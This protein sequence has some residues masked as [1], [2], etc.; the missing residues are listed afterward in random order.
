MLLTKEVGE[1]AIGEGAIGEG[2]VG[3]GAIGGSRRRSIGRKVAGE[4]GRW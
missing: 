4:Q 1:G 2:A 3:E